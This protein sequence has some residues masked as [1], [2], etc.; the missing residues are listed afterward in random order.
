MIA[1]SSSSSA[2]QTNGANGEKVVMNYQSDFPQLPGAKAGGP[3]TATS[4]VHR[5]LVSSV[6]TSTLKLDPAE[7]ASTGLSNPKN[8]QEQQTVSVIAAATG[9]KIELHESSDKS[10]TILITGKK[11]NVGEAHNRLVA[12]LQKQAKIEL[13]IPKEY[14]GMLIG[15]I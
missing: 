11:A 9:T 2:P 15:E 8:Q 1:S 14:Y 13:H 5:P 6:V 7:R 3:P 10:L 4:V 12:E